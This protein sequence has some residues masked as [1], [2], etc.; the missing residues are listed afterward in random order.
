MR[1]RPYTG[2]LLYDD[3]TVNEYYD[4]AEGYG[5]VMMFTVANINGVNKG[6]WLVNR[7][8]Y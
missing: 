6:V 8:R 2:H 1:V 7:W 3:T 4:F 5:G